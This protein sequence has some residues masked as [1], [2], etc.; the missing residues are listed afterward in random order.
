MLSGVSGW[1][2]FPANNLNGEGNQPGPTASATTE[3]YH[4]RTVIYRESSSEDW[5]A[6]LYDDGGSTP[7][8]LYSTTISASSHPTITGIRITNNWPL[9]DQQTY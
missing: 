7:V 2:Y 6:T 1:Y 9:V 3:M 5:T 4:L 8:A